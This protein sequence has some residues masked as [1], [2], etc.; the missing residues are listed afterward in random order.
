MY[1]YTTLNVL[2]LDDARNSPLMNNRVSIDSFS[3]DSILDRLT[4]LTVINQAKGKFSQE[5]NSALGDSLIYK[6][7]SKSITWADFKLSIRAAIS[8]PIISP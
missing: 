3:I 6:H 2:L 7:A 4:E 5:A 1:R 8:N